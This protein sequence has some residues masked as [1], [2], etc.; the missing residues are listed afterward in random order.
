MN[1]NK[2]REK[3]AE[4]LFESDQFFGVYVHAGSPYFVCPWFVD[5]CTLCYSQ[6]LLVK[7]SFS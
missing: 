2:S 6:L 5:W 3:I 1:P 7:V 4:I